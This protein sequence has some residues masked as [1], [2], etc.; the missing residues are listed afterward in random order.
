MWISTL[1]SSPRRT[2]AGLSSTV[3]LQAGD[4]PGTGLAVTWV[5]V[6]PGAS[7]EL[8]VHEPEQAYVVIAGTG[9]MTVGGDEA[10]LAPGSLAWA[11]PGVPH[12]I[13]NTGDTDLVYISAATPSFDITGFYDAS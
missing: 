6:A 1:A 12:G 7:Q 3:L 11:P 4:A 9:R 2:R 5:T 8:H 10:D 13:V